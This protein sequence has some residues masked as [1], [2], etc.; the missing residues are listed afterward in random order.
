MT[1]ALQMISTAARRTGFL[2]S[3]ETLAADDAADGL[4]TL[5]SMLDSWAA[6]RLMVYQ[7]QQE[8]FSTVANT[9]SYTMGS[10]G[11]WNTTRPVKLD[12]SSFIRISNID[13]PLDLIPADSYAGMPMKSNTAQIP[14]A[15]SCNYAYPL[16]TISLY[17]TPSA[18]VSVYVR[19]WKALQSFSA[20]TTDLA[21]PPG[22]QRAIE[23]NLAKELCPEYGRAVTPDIL[24]ES[25]GSKL[26]ITSVNAPSMIMVNEVAYNRFRGN[27]SNIY[28][29]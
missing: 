3:G 10:S 15:I 28:Q 2:A 25:V 4:A 29:G 5:N 12:N 20:L 21:L 11:T 13:Y 1:T 6:N 19:S 23:W 27:S 26:L 14:Y 9:A 7:I 17:P 16:A 24:R 8:V 22:Y 18:V